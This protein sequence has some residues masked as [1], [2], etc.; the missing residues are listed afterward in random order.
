MPQAVVDG[1]AAILP[2]FFL[3]RPNEFTNIIY[4]ACSSIFARTSSGGV[5]QNLNDHWNLSVY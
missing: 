1:L 5:D 4:A 2:S 3:N